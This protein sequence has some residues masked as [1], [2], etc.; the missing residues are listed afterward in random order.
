MEI[1]CLAE[2]HTELVK[3]FCVSA[4]NAGYKNNSSI[5]LMKFNGEYDLR[6]IPKFWAVVKDGKLISVS[7][8][9]KWR[10]K[11]PQDTVPFM[12]R[13]L[14]RSATLPIYQNIIPG[15]SK[16]HMNSLPF[17]MMLPYQINAGL[18]SGVKHFYITTSNTDHDASGKMKRT[19]RVLQLLE[20]NNIVK[21]AG[22]E[23]FYSTPQ[24]KWEINLDTYLTALRA[25]H[26]V[27]EKLK[28][29]L[30]DSYYKIIDQGFDIEWQGFCTPVE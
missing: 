7:G 19:H 3:E 5:E 21:Y 1:I 18:N 20:K 9:H 14:F 23:I 25:F 2:E 24:T 6:E 30:D 16:N 28:I 29:G 17:S 11:P 22:D 27:R 10:G 15:I 13:C 26:P 12:M 4:D 8:C